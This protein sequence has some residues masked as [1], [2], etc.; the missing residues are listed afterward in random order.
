MIKKKQTQKEQTQWGGKGKIITYHRYTFQFINT[1][2]IQDCSQ[3]ACFLLKFPFQQGKDVKKYKFL[4]IFQ[5]AY[6]Q[7]IS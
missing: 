1:Y 4:F 3:C 2:Y 5:K 6:I 7:F